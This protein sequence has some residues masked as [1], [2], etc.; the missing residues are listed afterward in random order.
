MISANLKRVFILCIFIFSFFCLRFNSFAEQNEEQQDILNGIYKEQSKA[1]GA[2]KLKEKLPR[3]TTESLEEIGLQKVDWR[4]LINMSP[5]KI[6]KQIIKMIK[7]LAP[8]PFKSVFCVLAIIL[9]CSLMDN[10][11]VPVGKFSFKS[12]LSVVSSLC[13]SVVIVMPMV[14]FIGRVSNVIKSCSSFMLSFVPIMAAIMISAGQV[15]S[16]GSYQVLMMSASQLISQAASGVILPMLSSLLAI[17]MVSSISERLNI[18]G[19]CRF[20]Y[21]AI[22]WTLSLSMTTFVSLLTLQGIVG[23]SSDNI[24]SKAARFMISSFVPVV[25][26]AISDAFTTVQSCV[27]LLKSSVGAFGIVAAE[28]I[29]L[30]VII[31]SLLWLISIYL[32]SAISDIFSLTKISDLLINSARVVSTVLSVILSCMMLLIISSVIVLMVSNNS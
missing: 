4:E 18:L 2:D 20:F 10:L 25:G 14:G 17:S 12:V 32:C 5:N 1:S 8:V 15:V 11:K 24:G 26:G 21:K 3:E 6:F 27:K 31:E 29:F 23:A 7:K 16:A 19:I 28:F 9:I 22:R 13:I 30:P